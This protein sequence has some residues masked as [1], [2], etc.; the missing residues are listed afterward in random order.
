MKFLE[1]AKMLNQKHQGKMVLIKL[2]VFYVAIGRSA[3][4]LGNFYVFFLR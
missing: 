3:L 1:V 2:G 4:A